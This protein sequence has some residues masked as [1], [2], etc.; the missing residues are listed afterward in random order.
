MATRAV[1]RLASAVVVLT[2]IVAAATVLSTILSA[3]VAGDAEDYLDNRI[4][5]DDFEDA[6]GPLSTVQVLTGL[7]TVATGVVTVIWM[8]R[9]ATNVRALGRRTTWHPLFAVFGW[10]LPPLVLYVIPFLMMRELWKASDP[11]SRA[12]SG[13]TDE[14]GWRR[15][16]ENAMLWVWFGLFGI[17]P[18]ILV[19]VQVNT[20]TAD[21]LP[22]GDT[23]S[24]ADSL[25]DF[26]A[27]SI[28]AA[29]VNVVAAAAWVLVVRQLTQRHTE[30]TG[31]V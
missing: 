20:L 1:S 28:V 10:F 4:S 12:I 5:E 7:A 24:V 2:I 3:T 29:I 22:A 18:L 19:V 31:E 6:L 30:L 11:R 17:A 16:G 9:M 13:E 8:Y 23:E 14:G 15:S 26:G 25:D 21:G 27:V